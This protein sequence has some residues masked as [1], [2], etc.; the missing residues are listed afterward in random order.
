MN[1]LN[2]NSSVFRKRI[3]ILFGLH[4]LF[5]L[6][7]VIWGVILVAFT[8][9]SLS[10]NYWSCPIFNVYYTVDWLSLVLGLLLI[11][12][13]IIGLFAFIFAPRNAIITGFE[14]R[15]STVLS[16]IPT[17]MDRGIKSLFYPTEI[18]FTNPNSVSPIRP[19][20]D[21]DSTLPPSS[22]KRSC[23][24]VGWIR[25]SAFVLLLILIGQIIALILTANFLYQLNN[26]SE[27]FAVRITNLFVELKTAVVA[28]T[29]NSVRAF[30]CWESIQITENCC[31]YESYL[32]W[33]PAFSG[34]SDPNPVN[35]T[36]NGAT[37][38]IG[39][40]KY[41]PSSCYC[42]LNMY[43]SNVDQCVYLDSQ[44]NSLPNSLGSTLRILR[45]N[46][47]TSLIQVLSAHLYN[48]RIILPLSISFTLIT[49]VAA[50]A[51]TLLMAHLTIKDSDPLAEEL[52]D[53]HGNFDE[54]NSFTTNKEYEEST[55]GLDSVSYG[56]PANNPQPIRSSVPQWLSNLPESPPPSYTEPD[57]PIGQRI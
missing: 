6:I 38:I 47:S 2:M 21:I 51:Y 42:P 56:E 20:T 32:D 15:D 43:Q 44:N 29:K 27:N 39:L 49:F 11:I 19:D 10:N 8:G 3:R 41:L 5:I 13:G 14:G 25:P 52:D 9:S 23:C 40:K 7:L 1:Q 18:Y 57:H 4:F 55:N 33:L 34:G 48:L 26:P 31:G 35:Y 54:P 12:L 17:N 24:K 50:L 45:K 22:S 37:T 28:D 36:A 46:C 53:N 30:E 16:N